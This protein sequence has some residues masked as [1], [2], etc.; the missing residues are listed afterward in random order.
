MSDVRLCRKGHPQTQENQR[1]GKAKGC[2]V[3]HREDQ[4]ARYHADPERHRAA[5]SDYQKRNRAQCSQR[6]A[7]WRQQNHEHVRDYFRAQ[8]RRRRVSKRSE[9]H[10]YVNE[11]LRRDPC[12]YCGG[13]GGSVDH[14]VPVMLGGVNDESNLTGC[15][16]RCNTEKSSRTLLM[17]L[18]RRAL[19]RHVPMAK[20]A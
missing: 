3:C 14:V 20:A 10:R 6:Q 4:K 11:V 16:E 2:A 18:A 5:A 12:A 9:T 8:A 19:A 13:E 1:K 17:F 15:C 7:E